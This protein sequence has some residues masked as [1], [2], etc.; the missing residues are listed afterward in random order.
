MSLDVSPD[1]KEIVFDLLGD[2][3]TMPIAG[4]EARALTSG[5][6]VGHAAALFARRQ[7][8]RVHVRPLGRRQHL[9]HGPR[10]QEP[11]AGDEGDLPPAEQPRLDARLAVHRGAQAL[12]R[13]ALARR[14]RDLALSPHGR[15]GPADDQARDRAEGRRRA[16]VLAGRALPLLVRGH[17]AREDLRVQ[18]GPERTDLRHQAARPRHGQDR[19]LRDRAGRV[20]PAD[21]VAA[22]A[23]R[24]RSCAAFATSRCSSSRT[25][26]PASS[27]RSTTGSSATCRRRG[28][29]RASIPGWRGR[30]T[31]SRSCSGRAE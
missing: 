28:R 10:R 15:R 31:R 9:D 6:P 30:R 21:A 29:S 27:A 12:H 25:S 26:S 2:I 4:G 20:D 16:R 18:Q 1:G 24:S 3:Y 13:H 22:T 5:H 19:R 7:V 11:A 17:D 8:D 23:S 14:G